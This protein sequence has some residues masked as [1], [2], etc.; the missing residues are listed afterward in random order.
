[1]FLRKPFD[2]PT[3]SLTFVFVPGGRGP[4]DGMVGLVAGWAGGG[5]MR[6]ESVALCLAASQRPGNVNREKS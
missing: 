5:I 2:L 4:G 3:C 6:L 1:M